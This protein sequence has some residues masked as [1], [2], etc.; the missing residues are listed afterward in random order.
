MRAEAPAGGDAVIVDHTQRPEAHMG[1]IIVI[2]EG[3]RMVRIEP[4]VVGMAA[5]GAATQGKHGELLISII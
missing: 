3:K 2:G 4:A 1:R 5:F